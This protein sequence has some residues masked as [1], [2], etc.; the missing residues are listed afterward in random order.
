[1]NV[2]FLFLFISHVALLFDVIQKL[3][4]QLLSLLVV[5][6]LFL[7]HRDLGLV[8]LITPL[9]KFILPFFGF[10]LQLLSLLL[11][12]SFNF[13]L[14]SLQLLVIFVI[15]PLTFVKIL[16]LDHG[17]SVDLLSHSHHL[18]GRLLAQLVTHEFLSSNHHTG[19]LHRV[20]TRR[21]L[22]SVKHT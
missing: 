20:S 8:S 11:T 12:N 19:S 2:T 1:M 18:P 22:H 5:P 10:L 16:L 13:F 7:A 14:K 17:L 3:F 4:L 21:S 6:V 9:V 15:T